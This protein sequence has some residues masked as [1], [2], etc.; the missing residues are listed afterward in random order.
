MAEYPEIV[1]N[2]L[3][4]VRLATIGGDKDK[5]DSADHAKISEVFDLNQSENEKL[6]TFLGFARENFYVPASKIKEN[7][8]AVLKPAAERK[9]R[10]AHGLFRLLFGEDISWKWYFPGIEEERE[11]VTLGVRNMLQ[12]KS[13]SPQLYDVNVI[14]NLMLYDVGSSERCYVNRKSGCFICG[15]AKVDKKVYASKEYKVI[16]IE[17]AALQGCPDGVAAGSYTEL[18]E[19]LGQFDDLYTVGI[20]KHIIKENIEPLFEMRIDGLLW[21][22]LNGLSDF[23]SVPTAR[24]VVED[25][26]T[27]FIGEHEWGH[28]VLDKRLPYIFM[29]Y[30]GGV[31]HDSQ[32]FNELSRDSKRLIHKYEQGLKKLHEMYA[33]AKEIRP[34]IRALRQNSVY[35]SIYQDWLVGYDGHVS[36]FR[37]CLVKSGSKAYDS[38]IDDVYSFFFGKKKSF[39]EDL[40][41]TI[42]KILERDESL[43]E[44]VDVEFQKFYSVGN[45]LTGNDHRR[46]SLSKL[47]SKIRSE[48]VFGVLAKHLWAKKEHVKTMVE[49]GE[50]WWG[51]YSAIKKELCD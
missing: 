44:S 15:P 39:I 35:Q 22:L 45:V 50:S 10:K 38:G 21:D 2:L 1:T 17:E 36:H 41:E 7:F 18:G 3:F 13:M 24:E 8:V 28:V 42:D 49:L 51:N 43:F 40:S 46:V 26:A 12:S 14:A 37:S 6:D 9:N 31:L 48:I 30:V 27:R 20:F 19:R 32:L 16:T 34:D 29:D 5:V 47:D 4:A 23:L 11:K 25:V 33:V